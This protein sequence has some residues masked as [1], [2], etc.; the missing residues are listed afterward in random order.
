MSGRSF[1]EAVPDIAASAAALADPSRAAMC[2][3]LMDGRAWT[4][5]ELATYCG[6]ARSTAS[7]H[8]TLLVARGLVTEVR[9]GRHRYL[10]LAGERVAR[11]I[12]DLGVI[13]RD[14]VPTPPSLRATT[15]HERLLAGRTCYRHLAGRLG[16]GL[17]TQMQER[18]LLDSA[19][20]PTDAGRALLAEWGVPEAEATRARTCMDSTERHYHLAGPAGNALCRTFFAQGWIE[21]IGTTRAVRLTP[22]GTNAL[23]QANITIAS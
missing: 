1:P 13:A 11:A 19:W 5:G 15:A 21:R 4:L 22:T 9:Q 2:A 16:T 8:A 7:E 23:A 12:E 3:A 6:I 17:T 10:H 18:R 14:T 20:Q